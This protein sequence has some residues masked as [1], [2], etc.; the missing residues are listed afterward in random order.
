MATDDTTTAVPA[1]TH[2]E[3]A[4]GMAAVWRRLSQDGFVLLVG[5]YRRHACAYAL[6]MGWMNLAVEVCAFECVRAECRQRN[7]GGCG[8]L[9]VL[10]TPRNGGAGAWCDIDVLAVCL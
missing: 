6:S 3:T 9:L 10:M 7:G 2:P 5:S 1:T 8:P 4:W